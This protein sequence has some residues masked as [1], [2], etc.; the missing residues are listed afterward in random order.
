MG[1]C[2]FVLT[3]GALFRADNCHHVAVS[4][5][6]REF[7]N[8]KPR[9]RGRHLL[10]CL[11]TSLLP[12]CIF[13]RFQHIWFT[14]LL[15][16]LL[17]CLIILWCRALLEKLIDSQLV[18]KFPAFH[19]TRR[20]IT[21]FSCARHLSLSW[22]RSIQSIPPYLIY[23]RSILILPSNLR[24]GLPSGLFPSGFPTKTV[25]TTL[26]SPYACILCRLWNNDRWI[27]VPFRE[28][29]RESSL[30]Y[31]VRTSCGLSGL[32]RPKYELYQWRQ[33]CDTGEWERSSPSTVLP[34]VPRLP[35]APDLSNSV[36]N[37]VP[38]SHAK[39]DV[40]TPGVT[41]RIEQTHKILS[42]VWIFFS[43]VQQFP[44]SLDSLLTWVRISVLTHWGRMTQICVFNTRLFSLQNT[45]N[46]AIHRACLRMVL[47]TD[48]YRNLT[49]LWINL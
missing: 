22:A 39:F 43:S 44:V 16:Y 1:L 48:I 9:G 6:M 34:T 24:L 30:H 5:L 7:A 28:V 31:S 33:S 41:L 15:T 47:L 26:L 20:F 36:P 11:H 12:P 49:S 38:Q 35:F 40:P 32:E 4:I 17:T 13:A 25:Y 18:K 19:G 8:L 29:P 27:S 21:A 37:S 14:Y 45:L 23:W 3:S 42:C 10:I 46:Y 2:V